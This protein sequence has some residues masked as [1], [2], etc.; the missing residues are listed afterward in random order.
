MPVLRC[1][2]K[3]YF[4]WRNWVRRDIKSYFYA[5]FTYA[6]ILKFLNFYN[7]HQ[8]NLATLKGRFKTLDLHRRPLISW[9]PTDE[10]VINDAQKELDA[11]GANLGCRRICASLQK[12]KRL[13]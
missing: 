13:S 6:E 3:V 5:G 9:R 1:Q 4:Y 12:T 11:S 2:Q 10:E 7:G 8:I